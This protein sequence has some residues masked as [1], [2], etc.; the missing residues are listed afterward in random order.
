M[1]R[2]EMKTHKE[3]AAELNISVYT[4]QQHISASLGIIR[5]YLAKL[6]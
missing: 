4:V 5:S 1:S 6:V 2:K 3:I